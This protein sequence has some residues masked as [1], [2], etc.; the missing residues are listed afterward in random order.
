MRVSRSWPRPLEQR[1][2]EGVSIW[3]AWL[4]VFFVTHSFDSSIWLLGGQSREWRS[5]DLVRLGKGWDCDWTGHLGLRPKEVISACMAC[6][7]IYPSSMLCWSITRQ[8]FT[9]LYFSVASYRI[10][11]GIPCT[12]LISNVVANAGMQQ[13][14]QSLGLRCAAK[15]L[16]T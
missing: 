14:Q 9:L 5:R 13:Q 1:I 10:V 7:G 6:L 11:N 12:D 8:S 2:T 16:I 4:L 15:G 3:R